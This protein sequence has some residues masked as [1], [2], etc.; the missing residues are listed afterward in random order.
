[1]KAGCCSS[2]ASNSF[3]PYVGRGP[4]WRSISSYLHS[5]QKW[6][7]QILHTVVGHQCEPQ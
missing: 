1:M 7:I 6:N 5:Q 4:C 2:K 3:S